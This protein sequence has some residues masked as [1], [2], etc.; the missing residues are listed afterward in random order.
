MLRRVAQRIT[1]A[2]EAGMIN[3]VVET[4]PGLNALPAALDDLAN[5]R[6]RGKL[7]LDLTSAE[8]VND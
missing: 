8:A 7:V 3:P 2:L 4:R 6:T 1:D 5:R